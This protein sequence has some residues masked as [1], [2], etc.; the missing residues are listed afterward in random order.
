[1]QFLESQEYKMFTRV[2][3]DTA[4]TVSKMPIVIIYFTS[5]LFLDIIIWCRVYAFS[6]T[7]SYITF[8]VLAWFLGCIN[9]EDTKGKTVSF[10]KRKPHTHIHIPQHNWFTSFSSHLIRLNNGLNILCNTWGF[11]S[12]MIM[13]L[14]I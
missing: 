14:E 4:P 7:G 6:W 8:I 9:W 13:F 1:M 2:V 11:I 10:N 5:A 3:F 12:N